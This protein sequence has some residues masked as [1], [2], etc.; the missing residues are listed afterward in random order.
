M[1]TAAASDPTLRDFFHVVFKHKFFILSFFIVSVC[2]GTIFSFTAEPTYEAKA[3]LL[4]KVGREYMYVPTIPTGEAATPMV[5]FGQSQ[6]N[7]ETEIV[8]SSVLAEK[9]VKSLGPEVLY[10]DLY[11]NDPASEGGLLPADTAER[12]TLERAIMRFQENAMVEAIGE[13][14]VIEVSFK[15]KD[16]QMVAKAVNVLVNLYLDQ[17]LN[18]HQGIESYEFFRRQSQILSDKL[19]QAEMKLDAFRKQYAV[20]SLREEQ[21]LLLK[22]MAELRAELSRARSEEAETENHIQQLRLQLSKTPSAVL[23]DKESNLNPE[24]ISGF[25]ARLVELEIK[26]RELL[27]NYK[28]QNPL[29]QKLVKDISDENEAIRNRLAKQEGKRYNTSRTG[30]NTVY[31]RLHDDLLRNEAELE[32]GRAKKETQVAQ[33]DEYKKKLELLNWLDLDFDRLQQEIE[34]D[35]QNYRLY[36]IKSEESRIS[37]AMDAQKI[38]N[39]SVIALA[40]PPL[41]PISPRKTLNMAIAIFLGGIGGIAL[42]FIMEHLGSTLQN[43]EEV[44]NYIGVPVLASIPEIY[45]NSLAQDNQDVET[46]R[47]TTERIRSAV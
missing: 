7:S 32:A 37:H 28:D 44:R 11:A 22:H 19:K 21:D 23:I 27:N 1:N 38:A 4:V 33:L 18:I 41:K 46:N 24:V 39:V 2:L 40:R 30:I 12:L 26:K 17:R 47:P 6:I 14:N 15:H 42:A 35:R 36:L 25:Y 43:E 29:V 45:E 8:R 5:T 13:S 31:Q 9:V 20:T 34:V 3:Q 16:P 10:D